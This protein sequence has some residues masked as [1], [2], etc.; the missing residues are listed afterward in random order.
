MWCLRRTPIKPFEMKMKRKIPKRSQKNK[1]DSEIA[2]HHGKQ[3]KENNR[4]TP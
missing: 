4:K 3:N 2:Y 1:G